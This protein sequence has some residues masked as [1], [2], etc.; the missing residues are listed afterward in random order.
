MNHEYAAG[1]ILYTMINRIPYFVLVQ[2]SDGHIGFPK[3]HIEN[4]ESELETTL[5]EIK[6]ETS[7]NASIVPGFYK[8]VQY[9]KDDNVMKHVSY[10][11]AYYNQQEI[12]KHQNE[13]AQIYVLP[14]EEALDKLTYANS[15]ELLKQAKQEIKEENLSN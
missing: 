5:R 1:A 10:Y 11:L 14:F 12:V 9:E 3:G 2:E 4:N 7:V 13:I 8:K 6:E 15:K